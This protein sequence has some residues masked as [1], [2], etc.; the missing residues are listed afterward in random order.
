MT[1]QP[2]ANPGETDRLIIR[3]PMEKDLNP[4]VTLWTDPVV[5]QYIGGPRDAD[6]V[7]EFFQQY[8]NDPQSLDQEEMGLWWSIIEQG[9]DKFVGLNAIL[10][11]DVEGQ[12]VFDLGYFLLPSCWGQG[13]ATEAS[14]CVIAYAFEELELHS[15]VAIIDPRNQASQSVAIKLGM[16]L[17]REIPR[18]D[19]VTRRVYRLEKED[20]R[21]PSA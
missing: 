16:H 21:K 6:M 9:S 5:T 14:R 8:V 10:E 1:S 20:W 17:E 4:I 11:K 2:M 18:S 19:G 15:L 7:R 13:Y 3:T 12:T